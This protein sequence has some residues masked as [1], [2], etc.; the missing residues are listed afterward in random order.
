MRS[1]IRRAIARRKWYTR[2]K[3]DFGF[4]GST[5]ARAFLK[6]RLK[7]QW[8]KKQRKNIFGHG[9]DLAGAQENIRWRNTKD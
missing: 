3:R 7:K 5:R 2:S 9:V 4:V 1:V 8:S 6:R